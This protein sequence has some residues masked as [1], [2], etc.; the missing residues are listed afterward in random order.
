MI[1]IGILLAPLLAVA[2]TADDGRSPDHAQGSVEETPAR[3][4]DL[5]LSGTGV[6]R[7]LYAEASHARGT[8]VM[9]PGGAG[10][11]DIGEQGDPL[12]G[13]NFV[14]RTRSLWNA[15]G[16]AVLIPDA[17]DNANMRGT[18]S[19]PSYAQVVSDLVAY[20]RRQSAGP[21]FL[22]GTSQGSIAAMNGAASL[23]AGQIA[24]V[25]LTESVSRQGGSHETVFDAH[26]DQVIVP[27]LVVAN[28]DDACKVAPPEDAAKIAAA[29][30]HSPQVKV[31]YVS[32][33]VL[34]ST[35]CGS[36]SPHG[37][38]GIE[39]S[40]VDSIVAWMNTQK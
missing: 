3:V 40:V 23:R 12:H 38:Y 24:G 2:Q 1:S 19:S 18:R 34:R 14:V 36:L 16:Y 27:A 32:G 11:V 33:G 26:P 37:Y 13:K 20:A 28:R 6:Q 30:T 21:I 4:V 17:I 22:L 39:Q 35:D 10:E 29:M 9:F 25:V 7:V 8:V 31:I 5:P 15:R